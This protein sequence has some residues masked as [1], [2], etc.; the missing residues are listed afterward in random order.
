MNPMESE[1]IKFGVMGMVILAQSGVIVV[2][3]NSMWSRVT[4]MQGE[5]VA[6]AKEA[7]AALRDSKN[8]IENLV[9]MLRK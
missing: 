1:W 6:L 8:Q 9:N 7:T 3:W 5:I 2:L 4:S